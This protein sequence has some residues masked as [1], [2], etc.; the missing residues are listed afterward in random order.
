MWCKA[1]FSSAITPD[2]SEMHSKM[3]I[4]YRLKTVVLLNNFVETMIHFL[5]FFDE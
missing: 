4:Y 5:G 1:E 2:T 3:P